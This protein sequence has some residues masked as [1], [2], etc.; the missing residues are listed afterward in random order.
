ME[1]SLPPNSNMWVTLLQQILPYHSGIYLFDL[2]GVIQPFAKAQ[3]FY[4]LSSHNYEFLIKQLK[5]SM[6]AVGR[7]GFVRAF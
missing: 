7:T 6:L 3:D 2:Y 5:I 1:F 4:Y